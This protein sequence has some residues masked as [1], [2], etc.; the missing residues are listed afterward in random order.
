M[1]RAGFAGSLVV[2]ANW[3]GRNLNR[4]MRDSR[5]RVASF[6]KSVRRIVAGVALGA[7]AFAA[8]K[9]LM[10]LVK[11]SAKGSE[12]WSNW[13]IAL[14]SLKASLAK[15]VAGPAA[16]LLNWASDMAGS[17]AGWLSQFDSVGQVFD[18]IMKRAKG[19]I[20]SSETLKLI[21]D[22]IAGALGKAS[23]L[24][25]DILLKMD[26]FDTGSQG[27]IDR[28]NT[29]L[30]KATDEMAAMRQGVTPMARRF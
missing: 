27:Q 19:F 4:G 20:D 8:G 24:L 6:G 12:A 28:G 16:N 26:L 17:L 5:K 22:T 25:A 15:L 29:S 13:Q 2:D 9:G 23:D 18:D 11:L 3:K 14:N 1:A 10:G 30:Y 7:G 21:W